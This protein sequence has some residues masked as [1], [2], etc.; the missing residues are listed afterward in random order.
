M[1]FRTSF[2]CLYMLLCPITEV[3]VHQ[4]LYFGKPLGS[5]SGPLVVLLLKY[6]V[7]VIVCA[8]S[9]K[10]PVE[11][12]RFTAGRAVCFTLLHHA[13]CP[14]HFKNYTIEKKNRF[15]AVVKLFF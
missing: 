8:V 13:Q 5:R 11:I 4:L 9:L 15:A 6:N 10:H 14:A 12:I 3:P 2:L 1:R 7:F